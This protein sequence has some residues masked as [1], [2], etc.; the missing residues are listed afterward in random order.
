MLLGIGLDG[1]GRKRD[2]GT[3]RPATWLL[4]AAAQAAAV[5]RVHAR[6]GR[7]VGSGVLVDAGL[8]VAAAAG[9]PALLTCAHVCTDVPG[10]LPTGWPA[11]L[12]PEEAEVRFPGFPAAGPGQTVA[13][14]GV[15]W[16]APVAE[17]DACLLG[18]AT[19]PAGVAPL[20]VS[21]VEVQPLDSRVYLMGFPRGEELAISMEQSVVRGVAEGRLTYDLD[22]LRGTSGGPI[23]H[24]ADLGLVAL[25]RGERGDYRQGTL[26]EG[27]AW[28]ARQSGSIP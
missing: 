9:R 15:L 27:L 24:W 19:P 25:H 20:A 28:V 12:A 5:G 13:V 10:A 3:L 16:R 1:E 8:L 6:G 14:A 2:V 22:A 23:F 26:L 18:L 7:F 21:E 17:L 4:T 11:P